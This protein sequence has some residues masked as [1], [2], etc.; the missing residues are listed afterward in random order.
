MLVLDDDAGHEPRVI[1]GMQAVHEHA[2]V[3][4]N[5]DRAVGGLAHERG[6]AAE[7][8]GLDAVLEDVEAAL[9]VHGEPRRDGAVHL[10]CIDRGG[11]IR[12]NHKE[13]TSISYVDL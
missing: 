11:M 7:G 1:A 6:G 4:A 8:A 3:A 12:G 5:G 9:V 13:M 10:V 2:A